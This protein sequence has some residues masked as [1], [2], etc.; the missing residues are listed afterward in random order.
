MTQSSPLRIWLLATRPKTLA[1]GSVPVLVA[2]ALAASQDAFM[3]QPALLC[4][5]FALL[6]Q[7]A[8]N[9]SNDYFDFIKGTDT[10]D[11][12]G[13]ERAVA[14]GW[15]KPRQMLIATIAVIATASLVGM[16]LIAYGGWSL[17]WVGIACIVALLA[18]TAGPW[19]LAYHGL[20]DVFVLVFFGLVSV[21]FTYYVQTGSV[22]WL[23]IVTGFIVGLPAVNILLLNN[24][25][26]RDGDAVAGKNTTVVLFGAG[27][28]QNAYLINGLLAWLMTFAFVFVDLTWIPLMTCV[29]IPLHRATWRKMKRIDHGKALNPLLGETAR[30]LLIFGVLLA[31]GLI[32]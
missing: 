23:A 25:R 24:Y 12:L 29:Y 19:P 8:S 10:S 20:G 3:W 18:Y 9:F 14:S 16:G 28:A 27:F 15:I 11:R 32:I 26:D 13:P 17:I 30:N 6:A 5:L 1:A 7:I 2:S 4:L 22:D 21:V 31:F